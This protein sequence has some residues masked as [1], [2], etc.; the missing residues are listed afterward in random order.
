MTSKWRS[1]S[2]DFIVASRARSWSFRFQKCRHAKVA[3][4]CN[5]NSGSSSELIRFYL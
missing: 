5:V 3:L 1:A 2:R 4:C